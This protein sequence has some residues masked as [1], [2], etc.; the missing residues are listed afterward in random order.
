MSSSTCCDLNSKEDTPKL[1]DICPN[2]KSECEKQVNYTP[3]Y[4]QLE[5]AGYKNKSQKNFKRTQTTWKKFIK[6]GL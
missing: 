1:H 2:F 3:N 5:G 6:P 4:F